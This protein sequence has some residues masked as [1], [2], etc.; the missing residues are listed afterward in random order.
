MTGYP[1]A[2]RCR[3]LIREWNIASLFRC[4]HPSL[5]SV[6]Q[7]QPSVDRARILSDLVPESAEYLTF[8]LAFAYHSR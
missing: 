3:A 1:P 7:S 2:C 5:R 8:G 4:S 6:R